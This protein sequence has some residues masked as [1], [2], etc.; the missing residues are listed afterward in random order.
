MSPRSPAYRDV[1]RSSPE[2][3]KRTPDGNASAGV[4]VRDKMS[5]TA[6]VHPASP[7]VMSN[8]RSA[9]TQ[10]RLTCDTF[11]HPLTFGKKLDANHFSSLSDAKEGSA[12]GLPI[13]WKV[14]GNQQEGLPPV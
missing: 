1:A 7:V 5:G 10:A 12:L 9:P 2:V 6:S 8:A 4:A 3:G 14:S 11:P 13:S